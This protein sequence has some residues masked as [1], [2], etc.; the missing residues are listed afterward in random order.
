MDIETFDLVTD[1]KQRVNDLQKA[2]LDLAAKSSRI[3]YILGIL[4]VTLTAVTTLAL[5]LN[6]GDSWTRN[7]VGV[8]GFTAA[9]IF[10]IQ[11]FNSFAKRTEKHRYEV[12]HLVNIRRDIELF[13]KFIP[14][15]AKEREQRTSEIEDRLV[16]VEKDSKEIDQV[17]QIRRWPYMLAGFGIAIGL[18][19]LI[20]LIR[21]WY[22]YFT[23]TRNLESD[24][25][26]ETIQQGTET[27]EFDPTDPLVEQRIILVNTWINEMTT[28]KVITL[29]TYLNEEDDQSP[30]TILLSSTGG[31]SK[32]GYAIANAIQSS[33]APVNTSAIG[34]CFSACAM[35]L[36][37]GTG[38]RN[39]ARISRIAIHIHEYPHNEDPYS[40]DMVRYEREKEFYLLHAN[41]PQN[42]FNREEN[43]YY[44]S[45]EQALKFEVIDAIVE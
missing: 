34:D 24:W 25:V 27:W 41:I 23:L 2:S 20:P 17:V 18:I 14:K 35:I 26:R 30:I 7:A 38:E 22:G 15:N 45:P 44:L 5:F 6:I 9:I 42:W 8:A 13:E 40:D 12:M 33:A 36:V 31:Y 4:A 29:L 16:K 21:N 32:D 11:I 28:Q 19:V 37:S 1:W 39:T 10:T 3:H 43:L